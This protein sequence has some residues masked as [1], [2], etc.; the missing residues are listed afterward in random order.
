MSLVGTI[1]PDGQH[2]MHIAISDADGAVHG[3]HVYSDHIVYTT[4]KFIS[5]FLRKLG[6]LSNV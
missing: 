1:D 4:G 2:H 5:T 6:L 3:G